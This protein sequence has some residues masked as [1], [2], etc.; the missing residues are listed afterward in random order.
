MLVDSLRTPSFSLHFI[1]ENHGTNYD[2]P[3]IIMTYTALLSLAILRDDF[4]RLD[5]SGLI[6]FIRACQ[7]DDGR[8]MFCISSL[9]LLL[10]YSNPH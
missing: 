8:C 2:T 4:S 1:Q 5:R 10:T 6:N 9:S 3:H 7:K